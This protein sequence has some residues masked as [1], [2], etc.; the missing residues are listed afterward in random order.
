MHATEKLTGKKVV[1]V[2]GKTLSRSYK[3]NERQVT[4][5][6]ISAFSKRGGVVLGQRLT[7]EKSN[8]IIAVLEL[9]E[10]LELEHAMVTLNV[11]SCQ[12]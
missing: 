2:D 5:H 9:L 7:D 4:L 3:H 10:L 11:M 8:E 12:K 1:A 6:M